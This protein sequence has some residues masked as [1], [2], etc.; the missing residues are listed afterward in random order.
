M[1]T[2]IEGD[3]F[4]SPA[5]VLVNAVNT[6]GVMGKGIALEFKNRYPDMFKQ[7]KEQCDKH[8]LVIGKLMLWYAPDHWILQFPTKEHWRNPSKMEYIEKGLMTFVRK[9]A[10]YNISSVAFPKLGCG[11]GEL[12]WNDVKVLMEKYLKDLPIDVYIYL[13]NKHDETPEHKN[14]KEMNEFLRDNAIDISFTGV[15]DV[16]CYQT[17][18]APIRFDMD[19]KTWNAYWRQNDNLT[20]ES[21][22]LKQEIEEDDVHQMWDYI[23][24]KKVFITRE[25]Q[26]EKLFYFLLMSLGYLQ[27]IK[28]QSKDDDKMHGGYQL[29]IGKGRAFLLK[30]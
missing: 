6:V 1:L 5:Q 23:C 13:G 16:I 4:N 22:E 19:G 18:I 29:D 3:I 12:N 30:G 20:F 24:N 17:A 8:K 11:N 10:D 7:Y 25:N 27:Q 28:I 2:Y 21:D 9:Y 15:K 14:Q 26:E